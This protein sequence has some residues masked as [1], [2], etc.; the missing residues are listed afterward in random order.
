M[1]I[2]RS[3]L[4]RIILEAAQQDSVDLANAALGMLQGWQQKGKDVRDKRKRAQ[5]TVQA[6]KEFNKMREDGA[7]VKDK[8]AKLFLD[9]VTELKT[10]DSELFNH[11]KDIGAKIKITS[12]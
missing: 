11:F 1:K 8:Y 2:T 10:K 3:Q 6:S 12:Y 5:G 9:R 4:R 7:E